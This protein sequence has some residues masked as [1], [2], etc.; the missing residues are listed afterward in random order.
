MLCGTLV[1][2]S[3]VMTGVVRY[4]GVCVTCGGRYV[5]GVVRYSGVCVTCGGRY[6]SPVVAGM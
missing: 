5:T 2:V 1:Y 3:P 6:V 4:T